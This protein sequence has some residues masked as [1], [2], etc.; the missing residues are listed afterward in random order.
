[1]R[2][3]VLCCAV[4]LC[5]KVHAAEKA[6]APKLLQRVRVA[7]RINKKGPG[8]SHVV[9]HGDFVYVRGSAP[10]ALYCYKRDATG[11]LTHQH[12]TE[13]GA[14]RITLASAGDRLYG[15]VYQG[16]RPRKGDLVWY[17]VDDTGKLTEKGKV[18]CPGSSGTVGCEGIIIGPGRKA[19][20]LKTNRPG[21]LAWF[22]LGDGGAAA[23]GGVVKGKGLGDSSKATGASVMVLSPD[24][25]Q[26]YAISQADHA[27]TII[28]IKADGTPA[29]REAV[30]L[31]PLAAKPTT[32]PPWNQGF[33]WPG[34]VMSP[35]GKHLYVV[36]WRYGG[37]QTNAVGIFDRDAKTGRLTFR[38]RVTGLVAP[39]GTSMALTPDGKTG[40]VAALSHPV[41]AFRRDPATGALAVIGSVPKTRGHDRSGPQVYD[42]AHDA[43][44]GHLYFIDIYGELFVVNTKEAK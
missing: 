4:L 7:S 10:P 15:V 12:T 43:A 41:T 16:R 6:P 11:K 36:L 30:D 35:G 1:M 32:G 25:K 8:T 17:D 39:K 29:Y 3:L 38:A 19:L 14:G 28:D 27:I 26:L 9:I 24:G 44:R 42:F 21:G 31:T 13:L 18:E 2:R 20:Y 22:K 33:P 23:V 40:W 37:R 5:A 34:L